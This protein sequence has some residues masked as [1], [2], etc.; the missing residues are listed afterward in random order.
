[1]SNQKNNE[2]NVDSKEALKENRLLGLQCALLPLSIYGPVFAPFL[3]SREHKISKTTKART[4]AIIIGL[5][6]LAGVLT[7]TVCDNHT[8]QQAQTYGEKIQNPH[9]SK[10]I[11]GSAGVVFGM[12]G[13]LTYLSVRDKKN[14]DGR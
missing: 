2:M 10:W 14:R 5:M 7:G 3:L 1:M 6:S 4:C 12:V 13:A 9:M 8:T 11:A